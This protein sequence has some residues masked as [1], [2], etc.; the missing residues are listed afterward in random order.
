MISIQKYKHRSISQNRFRITKICGLFRLDRLEFWRVNRA[1]LASILTFLAFAATFSPLNSAWAAQ[2]VTDARG[3]SVTIADTSRIVS[4]GGAVTEILFAL[5]LQDKVVAVDQTSTYPAAARALPNAGYSRTLA[6]ESVLSAGPTVIL[7]TEGA[8]PKSALD[9][10]EAA[11][12]PV[13]IIPDAHSAEGVVA[14]IEAVAA[15]VGETEKGHALAEAVRQDFAALGTALAPLKD[16]PRAVFVLSVSANVPVVGGADTSADAM[17]KLAG[18]TNAMSSL[19]GYKPAVDEAAMAA[20]PDVVVV[21][22]GGGQAL[23]AQT[24]FALPAFKG[25]PAAAGQRLITLNGS[26][27]LGF[28]PRAPHAA[29]D[30]AA[31]ARPD[32]TL[33]PLPAHPWTKPEAP[34]GNGAPAP[35]ERP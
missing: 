33:P 4:I 12:V 35:A 27:L 9:V 20:E 25:T 29:R 5:G 32:A 15:A 14:K 34:A 24:I 19:S 26:Y 31:A 2:S 16:H 23:P 22:Q 17:L 1:N 10:L 7:A 30:L 28:G 6:P 3:R 13:V 11:S 18:L 8:G 21:M